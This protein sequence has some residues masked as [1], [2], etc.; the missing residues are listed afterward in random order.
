MSYAIGKVIYGVTYSQVSNELKSLFKNEQFIKEYGDALEE[1]GFE[2]TYSGS[3]ME[4]V[5]WFGPSITSINECKNFTLESL[6]DKINENL[7]THKETFKKKLKEAPEAIRK[8]VEKHQ[9]KVWI[10]WGTS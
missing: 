6:N 10:V 8:I 3:A 2:E 9:P 7:T 5:A 1:W 4:P